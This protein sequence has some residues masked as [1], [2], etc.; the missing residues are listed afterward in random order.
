MRRVQHHNYSLHCHVTIAA[1]G[2][3]GNI[4]VTISTYTD[5]YYSSHVPRLIAVRDQGD[6]QSHLEVV[7]M[8][9]SIVESVER[10]NSRGPIGV[11][12]ANMN[13]SQRWKSDMEAAVRDRQKN[14]GDIAN[15]V[16]DKT[17]DWLST[18]PE[19][20]LTTGI[21]GSNRGGRGCGY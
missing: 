7:H 8:R 11:L 18:N 19:M 20:R 15:M 3:I 16:P 17:G 1:F 10:T 5:T 12:A 9:N 13:P 21:P 6:S 4:S 14:Y 2:V